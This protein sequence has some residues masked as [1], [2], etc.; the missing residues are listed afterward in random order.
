[1]INSRLM[2]EKTRAERLAHDIDLRLL[3][4]QP[5]TQQTDPEDRLLLDLAEQ[6][7][8]QTALGA[9]IHEGIQMRDRFEQLKSSQTYRQSLLPFFRFLKPTVQAVLWGAILIGIMV[10]TSILVANLVGK[11]SNPVAGPASTPTVLVQPTTTRT[12]ASTPGTQEALP[13]QQPFAVQAQTVNGIRVELRKVVSIGSSLRATLCHHP[14]N[15]SAWRLEA[16]ELKLH[17]HDLVLPF[18]PSDSAQPAAGPDGFVCETFTA[19]YPGVS[20]VGNWTISVRRL[21]GPRETAPDCAAVQAQIDQEI[22]GVRLDCVGGNTGYSYSM[23]NTPAGI[24]HAEVRRLVNIYLESDVRSGPWI[25]D[26]AAAQIDPIITSTSAFNQVVVPGMCNKPSSL[27]A[28]PLFNIALDLIPKASGIIGGGTLKSGNFTFLM[29]LA[30]DPG[31]SPLKPYGSERSVIN[32]LGV[33]FM[34][35]YDGEPTGNGVEHFS[36]IWPFVMHGGGGGSLRKGDSFSEYEGLLLPENFRPDFTQSDVHM[37]YLARVRL[38]D[39]IIEGAALAFTLQRAPEG[40]RPVDVSLEPLAADE[41]QTAGM[42]VD[43]TSPLPFPT[44]PVP[45]NQATSDT[46]ALLDLMEFWQKPLLDSPGWIHLRTR[47]EMPNG[48]DLYAGLKE[49]TN[50]DWFQI[51]TQAKVVATIH[52]DRRMDGTVLQQVVSQNGKTTNLTF[53]NT[54][55]F[56]PY[57]LDLAYAVKDTLKAGNKVKQS[58]ITVNGK[59]AI[60]LMLNGMFTRRDAIDAASGAWLYTETVKLQTGDDALTGGSLDTRTTLEIA[61]R[62]ATPPTDV[63]ALLGTAFT[64]YTPAAPYGTPAPQGFDPSRSTLTLHSVPGDRFDAPSFWYGDISAEGY[65]LGR[66]DLGGTPGGYFCDRSVDGSKLAFNY[67]LSDQSGSV[68]SNS[69]RW[70]DLRSLDVIHKPAPEL[71][72]LGALSWSTKKEKLAVFGCKAN[73]KDCGLYL[74]DPASDQI[75]LVIPGVYADWLPIWSPD[76]S[77]IAFVDTIKEGHTLY[78]VEILTGQVAYRGKFNA[79]AWQAPAD[80]PTNAWGVTFPRGI[81]GSRCFEMK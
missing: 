56:K 5:F 2:D 29:G 68:L 15:D 42:N 48:N 6:F 25:F 36:G 75:Q 11:P 43:P 13:T 26:V 64:G 22:T 52:I 80:S 67:S 76:G 38:P 71:V 16:V 37:R 7:S 50:D 33:A 34:I 23:N 78:V 81:N 9:T 3:H 72:N 62:V 66:V 21:V 4:Q 70:F 74:L 18:Y 19:A 40:Y 49:Y 55:E 44:L 27:L 31:F 60:L 69:L 17:N 57:P 30:C 12:P 54:G 59:P 41:Q 8:G 61:E 14:P 39:G 73:Q 1:M 46:Q 45:A 53:G 47:T 51:D 28:D 10:I 79:D 58:N 20:P 77:Q 24:S 32:G 63:M 35:Q 65:L